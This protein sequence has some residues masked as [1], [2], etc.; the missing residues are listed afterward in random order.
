[1][2]VTLPIFHD[3]DEKHRTGPSRASTVRYTASQ[4][5]IG[6]Q[7]NNDGVITAVPAEVQNEMS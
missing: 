3:W 5:V 1:M 4:L 6:T 7:V 2:Q